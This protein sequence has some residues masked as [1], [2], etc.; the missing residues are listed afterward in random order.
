MGDDQQE[1]DD[2]DAVYAQQENEERS[3][4]EARIKERGWRV[5]NEFSREVKEWLKEHT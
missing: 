1:Q 3:Q 5:A 2:L 4:W